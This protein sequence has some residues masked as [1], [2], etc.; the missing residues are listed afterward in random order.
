MIISLASQSIILA[1]LNLASAAALVILAYYA[2]RIFV[3]MRLG[4]LEKGWRLITQGMVIMSSGFIF[5]AIDH[6]MPRG[7]L[8]YF[9]IDSVGAVLSLVGIVFLLVGLHSHYVVWYKKSAALTESRE[10]EERNETPEDITQN[11]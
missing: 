6:A 4:R 5:V 11:S 10:K 7:T 2:L 8:L 1:A 9:Y 3:H